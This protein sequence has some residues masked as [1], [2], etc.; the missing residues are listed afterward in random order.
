M[1]R[2]LKFLGKYD[3][4]LTIAQLKQA[5]IEEDKKAAEKEQKEIE[6]I[7]KEFENTYVKYIAEDGI[8]G[9]TLNVIH[10]KDYVRSERT[11]DWNIVYYFEGTEISFSKRNI[12][13]G[14][15]TPNRCGNSFSEEDLRQMTTIT[16]DEFE[17]YS[18]YYNEISSKLKD[19]IK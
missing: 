1:N 10:F 17:E 9:K 16:E 15:F 14:D 19:L 18:E 7:K 6:E 11:T 13:K 5:V 4:N 2:A 12:R 3:E 8:F